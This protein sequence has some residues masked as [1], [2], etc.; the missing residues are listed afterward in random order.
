MR[1]SKIGSKVEIGRES[2]APVLTLSVFLYVSAQARDVCRA[3][4]QLGATLISM[5]TRSPNPT[6]S[7]MTTV[8]AMV[9]A[10]EGA[11]STQR[12]VKERGGK[13]NV[14][15]DAHIEANRQ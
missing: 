15:K 10:S 9:A 2:I 5:M 11:L 1:K 6:E 8:M 4:I 14:N 7:M 12:P 13:E 3:L